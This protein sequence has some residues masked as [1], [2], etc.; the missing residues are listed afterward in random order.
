MKRVRIPTKSIDHLNVWQEW[1]MEHEM[2]HSLY[3][4]L[5]S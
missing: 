2:H 4:T 1:S 3:R 5:T